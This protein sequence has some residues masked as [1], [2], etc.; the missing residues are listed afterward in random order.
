MQKKSFLLPALI[1]AVILVIIILIFYLKPG[2]S[3]NSVVNNLFNLNKATSGTKTYAL[4]SKEVNTFF[5][6]EILGEKAMDQILPPFAIIKGSA[7]SYSKEGIVGIARVEEN[8]TTYYATA[9]DGMVNPLGIN[10]ISYSK[11][12]KEDI[13]D[14]ISISEGIFDKVPTEYKVVKVDGDPTIWYAH[15]FDKGSI[16]KIIYPKDSI[17]IDI[18]INKSIDEHDLAVFINTYIAYLGGYTTELV[19]LSADKM[20]SN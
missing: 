1:L 10:K 13:E 2:G 9:S 3:S 15:S 19:P 12:V 5:P 14:A 20:T 17:M 4:S 11:L 16:V 6:Q 18:T 7:E 8:Y